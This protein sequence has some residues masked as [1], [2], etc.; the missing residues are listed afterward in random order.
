METTS[1][2]QMTITVTLDED[3]VSINFEDTGPGVRQ[4]ERLFRPFQSDADVNGLGLYISRAIM[5]TFH[6]ELRYE[7]RSHGSVFIAS[8]A[9]ATNALTAVNE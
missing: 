3:D 5:Q 2:K 6:G 4:P 7:P 1:R 8:L 9:I